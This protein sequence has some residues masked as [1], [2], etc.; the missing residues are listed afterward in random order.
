MGTVY[1]NTHTH[2]PDLEQLSVGF[3]ASPLRKNKK[4]NVNI[5]I[6]LRL[7]SYPGYA[8][9]RWCRLQY[10]IFFFT[11]NWRKKNNKIVIIWGRG[12][13]PRPL[14]PA[15]CEDLLSRLS[16]SYSAYSSRKSIIKTAL[17][18]RYLISSGDNRLDPT[19]LASSVVYWVAH[20][21][22]EWT[23][24]PYRDR[25]CICSVAKAHTI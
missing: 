16:H 21:G 24:H 7:N 3:S 25:T 17:W 6:N 23:S 14:S 13:V 4:K 9:S 11:D 18:C 1:S 20:T 19:S 5:Y 2:T 15:I 10:T 22:L 8:V 12:R